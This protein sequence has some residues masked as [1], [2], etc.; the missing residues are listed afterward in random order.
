MAHRARSG[1]SGQQPM[2]EDDQDPQDETGEADETSAEGEESEGGGRKRIAGRSL[3]LFVGLPVILLVLTGGGAYFMG[4]FDAEEVVVEA[5][6]APPPVAFF[7]MPEMVVN[8]STREGQ[9]TQYLKMQISLELPS[10]KLKKKIEP[11]LPRIVD[12]FQIYLR[13]LRA[14]DLEGSSG[15]YRLKE[16]MIRRINTEIFPEKVSDV[17]FKEIIIQ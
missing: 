6:V 3:V 7:E 15:I 1:A 10:F 16:E 13:E 2:A 17:L 5:N 14:Q 8:L 9:R 12:M 4:F 11:V